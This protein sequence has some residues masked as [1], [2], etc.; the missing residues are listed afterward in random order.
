MSFLVFKSEDILRAIQEDPEGVWVIEKKK[1]EPT[2]KYKCTYT[3]VFFNIG[4]HKRKHGYFTIKDV[5]LSVG[6]ADK[7]DSADPR[8]EFDGTR[9]QLQSSLSKSGAFGSFLAAS[10]PEWKRLFELRKA[11]GTINAGS[12]KWHPLLQTHVSEESSNA[13]MRGQELEDPI[14]RFKIDWKPFPEAMKTF[15]AGQPKTQFYDYQKSYVDNDGKTQYELAKVNVNG[16]M[17]LVDDSN[18]H[19]FATRGSVIREGTV[20][21]QSVVSS[22]SWISIPITALKI[23]LESA[24]EQGFVEASPVFGKSSATNTNDQVSVPIVA[25]TT[26][27]EAAIDDAISGLI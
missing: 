19:L 8:N 14:V 22:A 18:L 15:L 20:M 7:N 17:V 11:D 13:E 10:N 5:I 26:A 12:R 4:D 25:T 2:K 1:K 27:D 16:E 21:I 24:P 9:L 6:V 23:V 3:D